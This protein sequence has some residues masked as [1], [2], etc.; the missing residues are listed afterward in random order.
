MYLM[1]AGNQQTTQQ[2]LVWFRL[3]EFKPSVN[4]NNKNISYLAGRFYHSDISGGTFL[5]DVLSLSE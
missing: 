3:G 1:D 4:I 2:H 5:S